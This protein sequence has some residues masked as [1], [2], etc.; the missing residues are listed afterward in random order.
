MMTP[1]MMKQGSLVMLDRPTAASQWTRAT[2]PADT[3]P[4]AEACM[5]KRCVA[6]KR[7]HILQDNGAFRSSR[8][9]HEGEAFLL[10]A[11]IDVE[12]TGQTC[13]RDF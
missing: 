9:L 1:H 8:C 4:K 6:Y 11:G 2:E 5:G 3:V 7:E 10:T 12:F 13:S